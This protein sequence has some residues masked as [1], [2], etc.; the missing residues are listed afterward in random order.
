M[1]RG[2]RTDAGTNA[3]GRENPQGE[4]GLA[5]TA[6]PS[7]AGGGTDARTRSAY[8]ECETRVRP[9]YLERDL[10]RGD[11]ATLS[12]AAINLPE[13]FQDEA[14][15]ARALTPASACPGLGNYPAATSARHEDVRSRARV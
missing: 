3:D 12:L 11:A 1:I 4:H 14:S 13:Y 10:S 7:A 5:P 8:R 9:F 6:Q 15:R 2:N